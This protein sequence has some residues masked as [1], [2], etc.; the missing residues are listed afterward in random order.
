MAIKNNYKAGSAVQLL[1][2]SVAALK[3]RLESMFAPGMNW[4][5]HGKGK[6]K[7]H[8]D[9]IAPLSSFDL[10]DPDQLRA[11]CHY[12]NLQP[13]WEDDNIAKGG[14]R[15]NSRRRAIRQAIGAKESQSSA[16]QTAAR[17]RETRDG[18]RAGEP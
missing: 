16:E 18:S 12:S 10:A 5:N 7:W 14:V 4:N 9:H 1:G 2:C 15:R 17:G 8:I 11:A 6:G 13:L 3:R